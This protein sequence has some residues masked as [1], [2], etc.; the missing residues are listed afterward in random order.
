[1]RL[2]KA[3]ARDASRPIFA[4]KQLDDSGDAVLALSSIEL[5]SVTLITE[6]LQVLNVVF[7]RI[8]SAVDAG[9]A[10]FYVF[11]LAMMRFTIVNVLR[12]GNATK[13]P[14]QVV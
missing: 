1:M 12:S 5:V 3:G 14:V 2:L 11:V 13:M 4:I 7:E 8:L 9:N 10:L 6:L